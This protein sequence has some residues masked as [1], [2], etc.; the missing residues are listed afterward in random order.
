M[1][2]LNSLIATFPS[3]LGLLMKVEKNPELLAELPSIEQTLQ[4]KFIKLKYYLKN[5][6]IQKYIALFFMFL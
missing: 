3:Q 2:F 1:V 5:N 4:S 6:N